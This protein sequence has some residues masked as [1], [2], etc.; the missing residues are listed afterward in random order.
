MNWKAHTRRHCLKSCWV[1]WSLR[2]RMCCIPNMFRCV[3]NIYVQPN[4]CWRPS[5]SFIIFIFSI[6]SYSGSR[7][8]IS[9]YF[10]LVIDW[11]LDW[12][13]SCSG[14]FIDCSSSSCL[15]YSRACW[16]IAFSS[17]D[18]SEFSFLCRS[19]KLLALPRPP[20]P[21]AGPVA[22]YWVWWE[23]LSFRWSR[24]S[25]YSA[26]IKL[27][28]STEYTSSWSLNCVPIFLFPSPGPK[29]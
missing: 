21:K 8:L 14:E 7:L 2:V 17:A 29:Q 27:Q 18:R 10:W 15:L 16:I 5:L 26:L 28:K 24:D 13:L 9:I 25:W 4:P 20:R 6:F 22:C 11:S 12:F 23:G 19:L 3:I 1:F